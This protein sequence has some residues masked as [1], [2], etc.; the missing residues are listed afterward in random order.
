[1]GVWAIYSELHYSGREKWAAQ[2]MFSLIFGQFDEV[3]GGYSI[4]P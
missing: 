3:P 2:G 1:M 4:V